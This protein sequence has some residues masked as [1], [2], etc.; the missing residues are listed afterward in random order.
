MGGGGFTSPNIIF[1]IWV[2][3][4]PGRGGGGQAGWDKIPSL[5]KEIFLGLPLVQIPKKYRIFSVFPPKGSRRNISF[6]KL[7]F[8]PNR[9]DPLPGGWDTDN[10][11]KF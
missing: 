6:D 5:S 1:L 7:G 4:P 10:K 11:K 8:C 3:Q 2:S 9:L